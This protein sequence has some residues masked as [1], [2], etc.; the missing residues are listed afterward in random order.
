L[1]ATDAGGSDL[2]LATRL[3]DQVRNW[4]DAAKKNVGNE[5]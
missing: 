2:D 1:E 5:Q 4:R 3:A